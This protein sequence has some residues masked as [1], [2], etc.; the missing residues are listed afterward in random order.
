MIELP[1]SPAPRSVSPRLIDYGFII[2]GA[3]SLRIE[4][5]GSRWALD[6]EYPPMKL[7][8]S[9]D[10]V[11]LLSRAKSEGLKVRVPTLIPQSIQGTPTVLGSGQTGNRL[12][13]QGFQTNPNY[14]LRAGFWFT[15][16]EGENAYLHQ[17]AQTTTSNA[18]EATVE[19]NPPLRAKHPNGTPARFDVPFIQGFI[20]SDDWSWTVPVNGLI[21]PTFTVE[22]YR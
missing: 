12:A 14:E 11:A 2:R 3:S 7:V 13:L 20:A 4:R 10:F 5:P 18:G 19:I 17:V 8:D 15:I 1:A 6:V 16:D 22:E 9:Y 21:A